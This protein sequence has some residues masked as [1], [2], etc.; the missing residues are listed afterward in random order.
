[1]SN[2][3]L[4]RQWAESRNPNS[5]SED[6]R[7]A[8][9]YILEHVAPQRMDEVAWSDEEHALAGAVMD[10]GNGPV[11]VIMLSV[12][13]DGYLAY[14]TLDGRVAHEMRY[15]FTPNGKR[16][17]LVEVGAEEPAHPETLTTEE[18]YRSA[19]VGTIA[20]DQNGYP[21]VK[22]DAALWSSRYLEFVP[23]TMFM[24]GP[25]TVLREG[26]GE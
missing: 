12:D 10:I 20:I 3:K 24:H 6:A 14:A 25:H 21:W 22:T 18:D 19:P 5:L 26:W 9:A 2:E 8:R 16:Y 15:E 13:S 4:A 17:K 1:M 23:Q 7:A 11:E